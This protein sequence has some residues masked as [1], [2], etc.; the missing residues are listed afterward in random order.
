MEVE[1]I[2]KKEE[3]IAALKQKEKTANK[4]KCIVG[5]YQ[6]HPHMFP[7]EDYSI[8][9]ASVSHKKRQKKKK[10]LQNPHFL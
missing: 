1:S 9:I 5:S 4:L 7:S 8:S 10:E 6:R 3:W 2:K